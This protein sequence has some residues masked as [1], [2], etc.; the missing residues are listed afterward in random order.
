[1]VKTITSFTNKNTAY[2][3]TIDAES[4]RAI[5]CDCKDM[6]RRGHR[7]EHIAKGG[8]KHMREY[9]VA[10]QRAA[11]FLILKR[12]IEQTERSVSISRDAMHTLYDPCGMDLDIW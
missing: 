1:M 8:C 10:L 3:L 7:A 6:R 9:E 4:G 2:R 5:D 12:E 11:A